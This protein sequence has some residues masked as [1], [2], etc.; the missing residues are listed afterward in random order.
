MLI[1]TISKIFLFYHQIS[2]KITKTFFLN[3]TFILSKREQIKLDKLACIVIYMVIYLYCS[4]RC[5]L[6]QKAKCKA[7]NK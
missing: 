4:L 1:S 2:T 7:P 5:N 3:V 6:K